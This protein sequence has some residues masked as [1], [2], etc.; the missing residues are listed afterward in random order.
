MRYAIYAFAI[1]FAGFCGFL[2]HNGAVTVWGEGASWWAPF[3]SL[4]M[5]L[6]IGGGAVSLA[7]SVSGK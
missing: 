3:V 2:L 5:G 4:I 7:D 6:L 1:I